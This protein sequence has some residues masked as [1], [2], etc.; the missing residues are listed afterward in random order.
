MK[1]CVA[2]AYHSVSKYAHGNDGFITLRAEDY[3]DNE[4]AAAAIILMVQEK[5]PD[6]LAWREFKKRRRPT[7]R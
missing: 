2:G 6:C 5:W 3:T 7:R 1:P 4:R